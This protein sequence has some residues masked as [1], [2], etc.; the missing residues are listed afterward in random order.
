MY[1]IAIA[2]GNIAGSAL[3]SLLRTEPNFRIVVLYD[4]N[5]D[6]PGCILARKWNIPAVND[7]EMI[8]QFKPQFVVNLIESSEVKE[9]L[10]A[11]SGKCEIITPPVARILWELIESRKKTKAENIKNIKNQNA[12]STVASSVEEDERDFLQKALNCALDIADSPAGSIVVLYDNKFELKVHKGLSQRFIESIQWNI[13]PGG[14]TDRVLLEKE[15]IEIPDTL[16]S[17]FNH[18]LLMIENIR[19]VLAVPLL[20]GSEPKGIMFIDDHRPKKFSF[21]QKAS[22]KILAYLVGLALDLYSIKRERALLQEH[23]QKLLSHTEDI[24][25]FTDSQGVVIE[26]SESVSI[27]NKKKEDLIGKKIGQIFSRKDRQLIQVCLDRDKTIKNLTIELSAGKERRRFL[28]NAEVITTRDEKSSQISIFLLKDVTEIERLRE[29]LAE[30][31]SEL[32]TLKDELSAKVIERTS[33]IDN[34]TKELKKTKEVKNRFIANMSHE[35]R[36]PLNSIIGFSD[37]LL[38]ET[39]GS[40]TEQQKRYI[41]NI[42]TS[43]KHL[44]EIVNNILDFAKLEAGKYDLQYEEFYLEELLQE[45]V[46]TIRPLADKKSIDILVSIHPDIEELVADRFKLKQILYNLLSN[47]I[48]FTGEKGKVSITVEPGD[49]DS[50]EVVFSVKDTGVGIPPDEIDRIF[51][52]FEQIDSSLVRTTGGTGLGLALT[53]KLVEI[54]GGKITVESTL[55]K[56]STFRFTIA[57]GTTKEEKETEKIE[58]IE[59]EP[60]WTKKDAPLILVVED[61]PSASELLTVHLSREG[62]RVAHAYNGEEAIEKAISMKPFAI[63]L[64]IMLPKKDG[65]EVLQELKTDP[66][67]SDIPVI[68]HSIVNNRELAFA[69]GATDYIL[70]PLDGETLL[71]KLK[72]LSAHFSKGNIPFTVL[73]IDSDEKEAEDLKDSLQSAGVIAYT[74][75]TLKRGLE[76]AIALRPN[77]IIVGLE[78]QEGDGFEVIKEIK[79]TAA[80]KDIPVFVMS[81][82]EI[83]VNERLQMLGKIE[84]VIKKHAF[85]TEE[86]IEHIRELETVYPK[87]AGLIDEVTGLF[88]HRY[89][90]IR[91]AQEID[92]AERYKLP[93]IL[94]II[95]IDHFGEYVQRCGQSKGNHVL[96][97]VAELLRKNIRGS[98]VVVRYGA[99][100]FALLLPNTVLSAGVSL[101]N[102]FIA[103]IKNYPFPEEE[104]QPKK[105]ITASAGVAFYEGQSPEEL[106]L[107]AEKALQSAI[108]KGGDRVDVYSK[109]MVAEKR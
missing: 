31:E 57:Q 18:P 68:I 5:P 102:R 103:I 28:L 79:D 83:S 26:C 100:S 87:R 27:L 65:W 92:R 17:E 33:V 35:L 30:K 34:L 70:K 48:K 89:F 86:L 82:K 108:K 16:K 99:D 63:I 106:I 104:G 37:I 95:D 55:G 50:Q 40:L 7:I 54:H 77:L 22:L 8:W 24:I 97:K 74:A 56:G 44:L 20:S 39:F 52:E 62:Y 72:T 78:Q 59:L 4:D 11:Y 60:T 38:E 19:S 84:R 109:G 98:D 36:T 2:G 96:K 58:P 61:D 6:S 29:E 41:Y 46:S 66:V 85:S 45:I 43:G 15:M 81:E 49:P 75:S 101:S 25:L 67:T 10:K 1:K 94:I 51:E 32:Q 105:M 69:L 12:I 90:H 3:L 53:K 21:R 73:I 64:D 71:Q 47:A 107:H 80:T 76:L 42:K 13:I 93:L 88:S 23:I 14:L 9:R 91:V